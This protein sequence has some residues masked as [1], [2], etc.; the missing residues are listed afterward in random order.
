M[1]AIEPTEH[2]GPD[3][4]V[5]RSAGRPPSRSGT[6]CGPSP[7]AGRS[8]RGRTAGW[9]RLFRSHPVQQADDLLGAAGIE[10]G[11]RLVEQQQLGSTDE[12]VGDQYPLLLPTRERP[13]PAVGELAR[14]RRR[15]RTWS[16]ASALLL[17]PP[18][19]PEPVS[20][21]PECDQVPC[22]HRHVR[23]EHDL[24][25][26]IAERPTTLAEWRSP[27]IRHRARVGRWLP[28][29]TR[30]SVVLPTPLDPISPVNS[31]GR[32]SKETSSRTRPAPEGD[33]DPVDLEDR[34][35]AI[36]AGLTGAPSRCRAPPLLDGGH[37]GLHPGLVVVPRS[38]HG[39][40]DPDHRHTGGPGGVADRRRQRVRPPAG[41][42]RTP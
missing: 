38:G 25:G 34:A 31:P 18:G 12:G 36:G 6:R 17:R 7:A 30:S 21:E 41:C 3:D 27:P 20:V 19:E 5:G 40:I 10:V 39:L 9:R 23:V 16:T 15:A 13:D 11:Q 4:L 8:S 29:M 22:P 24:L 26:Y 33:P 2:V 28:R 32:I 37:L 42:S 1:V 35:G 14:R